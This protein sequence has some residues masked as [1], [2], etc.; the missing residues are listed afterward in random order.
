MEDCA[1]LLEVASFLGLTRL[2]S[3]LEIKLPSFLTL[4]SPNLTKAAHTAQLITY[5]GQV[6]TK[7]ANWSPSCSILLQ[8]TTMLPRK[9]Q[10]MRGINSQKRSSTTLKKTD[11][12]HNLTWMRSAHT[13]ETWQFGGKEMKRRPIVSPAFSNRYLLKINND[14]QAM[15]RPQS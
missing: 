1:E 15:T 8:Q 9:E 14:K 7:L 12:L 6:N 3:L 5:R 11:G 2:V 10:E 13:K 4:P